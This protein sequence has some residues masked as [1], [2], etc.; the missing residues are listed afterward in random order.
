M[1]PIRT[2][3]GCPRHAVRAAKNAGI[4]KFGRTDLYVTTRQVAACRVG[5]GERLARAGSYRA[6]AA[7]RQSLSARS[8]IGSTTGRFRLDRRSRTSVLS[9]R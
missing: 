1:R 4:K 5:L 7:A 3:N 2:V 6:S 8:V 9:T